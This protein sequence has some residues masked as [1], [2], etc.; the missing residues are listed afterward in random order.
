MISTKLA[1]PGLLKTTVL[2]KGYDFIIF[3][4]DTT[5]KILSRDWNFIVDV[6]VSPK[7]STVAF[8]WKKLS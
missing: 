2:R 4:H 6:V 7:F 3:F 1:T 8:L 5:N